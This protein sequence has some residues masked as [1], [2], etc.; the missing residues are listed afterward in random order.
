MSSP[1]KASTSLPR[2]DQPVNPNLP[3]NSDDLSAVKCERLH[4]NFLSNEFKSLEA[5]AKLSLYSYTAT[6]LA[7]A[8]MTCAK[9]SK[10]SLS[11]L[12]RKALKEHKDNYN[13]KYKLDDGV[14]IKVTIAAYFKLFDDLFF[15]GSLQVGRRVTIEVD[16]KK[17]SE[18]TRKGSSSE[19]DG[20]NQWLIE[21][22]KNDKGLC[23][24]VEILQEKLTTLMH[25]MIHVYLG[26]FGCR[27][28]EENW[29]E[30][31]LSGHGIAFLDTMFTLHK[32]APRILEETL[33]FSS[34]CLEALK[35]EIQ[36]GGLKGGIPS[37]DELARWGLA[38][39]VEEL[40]T[41]LAET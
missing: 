2:K 14:P 24:P 18:T 15:L 25:E 20:A 30:Q 28:C 19:V 34:I 16:Q 7:K 10:N 4:E 38:E 1:K 31:G 13:K 6:E 41:F 21:I 36:G 3:G 23:D 11:L 32:E 12:Q 22:H 33:G 35:E 27:R 26:L 17:F 39:K 5:P 9:L 37:L 8:A 29:Q 40:Q